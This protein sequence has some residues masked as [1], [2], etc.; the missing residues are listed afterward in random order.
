MRG[1][2][3]DTR[4][5]GQPVEPSTV[6]WVTDLEDGTHP[7]Y[8]YGKTQEEVLEKLALQ[9]A[10]AQLALARKA[11]PSSSPPPLPTPPPRITPDAVLQ[12]TSDLEDPAKS[13]KAIATLVEASTGVSLEKLALEN[14][15]RIAQEWE[16]EHPEFYSH[17]GNQRLLT[18][19]ALSL[20]GGQLG[21][22]TKEYLTRAQHNLNLQGFLLPEPP[23][24]P[25]A[26]ATFPAETQVQREERPPKSTRFATG[27]R[28]SGFQRQTAPTRTLKYSEAEI[29]SMPLDKSKQLIASNDRDY[30]EACDFYF[31]TAA[32]T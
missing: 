22:I 12:A 25:E 3:T 20:A 10:N 5:N 29:R 24:L 2:W 11:A 21:H 6:C 7:I 31:G 16:T 26:P 27:S 14:F 17:P 18:Q 1:Y 32:R 15:S 13:G 30:A 4:P 28:S 8:T 9:N 19:E 23:E